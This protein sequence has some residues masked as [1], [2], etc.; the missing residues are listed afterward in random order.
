VV[1]VDYA[2]ASASEI[3]AGA[4]QDWDRGVVL[5]DTTFGKGSVQSIL[6]LDAEHKL[7]L[8][9]AFYYTP[10]GRCINKPENA[11]RGVGGASDEDESG[12]PGGDEGPGKQ[13][14]KKR[15]GTAD[16]DTA[17]AAGREDT[18]TYRTHA[19]RVVRGGGGIIPDT[20]VDAERLSPVIVS[21]LGKD[22]F[23]KFV[24]SEY[25]RLKKR[26]VEVG[27]GYVPD[28]TTMK[29]FHAYLD[30]MKFEFQTAAQVRFSDFKK[31]AG[32]APDT[33][34]TAAKGSKKATRPA[35]NAL[36]APETEALREVVARIDAILAD[37]S[38]RSVKE[39]QAEV[40]RQ[41]GEWML[42]R[43]RGQDDEVVYRGRLAVDTQLRAAIDVLKDRK[44]YD[45]LLKPKTKLAER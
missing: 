13:P 39:E 27:E 23:F 45:S 4:I 6:P 12:E 17:G 33:A 16:R 9:T 21:L 40:K 44:V 1:L 22:L 28:G 19:G 34:D 15:D 11:V 38:A 24:N 35:D 31:Q 18:T 29:L 26:G 10:S 32:L 41:L 8:T 2:S 43:A 3:V 37:A 5:G 36:S 25:P 14:V 7:K 20:I 30:S 42:V